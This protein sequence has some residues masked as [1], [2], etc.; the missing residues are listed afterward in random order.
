MY[1]YI[2]ILDLTLCSCSS[3]YVA[4]WLTLSGR[5][6]PPGQ[7]LVLFVAAHHLILIL[8]IIMKRPRLCPISPALLLSG[9]QQHLEL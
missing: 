8:Y 7:Q 3:H 6:W 5:M 4:W 1:I 2:Y 9:V